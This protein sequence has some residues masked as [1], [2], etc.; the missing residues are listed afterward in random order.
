MP[1]IIKL[2]NNCLRL[3]NWLHEIPFADGNSLLQNVSISNW[4]HYSTF[5]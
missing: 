2:S 5:Y 1:V 4:V 3:T